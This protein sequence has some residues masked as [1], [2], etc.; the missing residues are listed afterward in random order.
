MY[1]NANMLKAIVQAQT[2]RVECREKATRPVHSIAENHSVPD[3][4]MFSN[5]RKRWSNRDT[6]IAQAASV[7][8]TPVMAVNVIRSNVVRSIDH[9][10]V[11]AP[12]ESSLGFMGFDS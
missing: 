9:R 3:Q 4:T 7:N 11:S 10:D 8:P 2:G 1:I 12:D 5:P 6:N